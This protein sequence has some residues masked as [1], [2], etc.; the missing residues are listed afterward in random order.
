MVCFATILCFSLMARSFWKV[1]CLQGLVFPFPRFQIVDSLNGGTFAVALLS[2]SSTL[3]PSQRCSKV[4]PF[5]LPYIEIDSKLLSSYF[6]DIIGSIGSTLCWLNVH[7]SD[8]SEF[9]ICLKNSILYSHSSQIIYLFLFCC[10]WSAVRIKDYI[11]KNQRSWINF[12]YENSELL[13]F[14]G[15]CTH[16][17]LVTIF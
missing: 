4:N 14:Y 7:L 16:G 12:F 1:K 15:W 3:A 6:F 17:H 2:L 13:E 10:G 11:Y 9:E 8:L 5:F